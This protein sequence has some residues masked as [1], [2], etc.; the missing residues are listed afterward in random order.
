V[1]I[2]ASY[3]EAMERIRR[4][5]EEDRDLADRILSWIVYAHRPLSLRELQH[6][7]AISPQMA[8]MDC[9]AI[10]PVPILTAVCAGVVVIDGESSI[11]R[12]VRKLLPFK[13]HDSIRG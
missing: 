5:G 9:A 13:M 8:E 10:V 4:Q 11:I 1:G 7:V 6:A 2:K 3:D 12:P